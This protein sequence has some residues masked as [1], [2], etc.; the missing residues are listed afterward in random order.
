MGITCKQKATMSPK[1]K[2]YHQDLLD[3][4]K[5]VVI[6]LGLCLTGKSAQAVS[7]G[8]SELQNG[9]YDKLVLVREPLVSKCGCLKG[10]Y[11]T[12]MAP[13]TKQAETYMANESQNS[14]EELMEMG[15][16]E[17]SEPIF[18]QGN[19]FKRQFVIC[20]EAQNIHK[21]DTFKIM[22]RVD[23]GCKLVIV[24]DISRGQENSRIKIEDSM[25][26]YLYNKLKDNKELAE[27]I[28]IHTFYD[29]EKDILGD[30]FCKLMIN[31]LYD[32]FV[33]NVDDIIKL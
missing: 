19:R 30:D 29:R 16:V 18:L 13:Y 1:L 5:R 20:D 25:P 26:F 32:D 6:A 31:A 33:G 17:V 28:G 9:Y 12:K 14:F 4:N 22:S 7:C 23:E 10:D 27:Y 11:R 8:M 24:G 21:K 15:R 3:M 2:A